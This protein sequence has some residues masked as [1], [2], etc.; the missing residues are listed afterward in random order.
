MRNLLLIAIFLMALFSTACNNKSNAS[1]GNYMSED[2]IVMIL[3]DLYLVESISKTDEYKSINK[4]VYLQKYFEVNNIDKQRFDESLL[5][6][7]ENSDANTNDELNLRVVDSL[8]V[9]Q[10]S[11]QIVN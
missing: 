6:F 9:L 7:I 10:K 8:D 11:L 2:S 4:N 1:S 3:T 5:Y